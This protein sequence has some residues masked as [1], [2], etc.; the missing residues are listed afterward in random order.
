LGIFW[1]VKNDVG[2]YNRFTGDWDNKLNCENVIDDE[3]WVRDVAETKG[4]E[5]IQVE[6]ECSLT[7]HEEFAEDWG[8]RIKP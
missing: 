8:N 2:Y 4:G 1:T 3:Q 5:A 7:E 6:H